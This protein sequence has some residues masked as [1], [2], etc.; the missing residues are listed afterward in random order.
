MQFFNSL[1][2]RSNIL[3]YKLSGRRPW[4]RGYEEYK[5][6]SIERVI[7]SSNFK[8]L[9][10]FKGYGQRVDERI[11]EYPWFFS[12]L[13]DQPEKLLDAGSILNYGYI[14]NNKKLSNKKIHI[15]TLSPEQNCYWQKGVSYVFDD[16]RSCPYK[17][18]YFDSIVCISTVEHIGLDNTMLYSNKSEHKE[19]SSDTFIFAIREFKRILKV[20]GKLYLTVPFGKHENHGWFQIFNSNMIDMIIQE[21]KPTEYYEECFKY[22][23][24]GWHKS[25][26]EESKEATY[27]D[28]HKNNNYDKDFAAASRAVICLELIK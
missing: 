3:F 5:I 25:T 24:F 18:S 7:N 15:L 13:S 17:D 26:R 8:N 14:L 21:F 12:R 16:I 1:K 28:I 10:S 9:L 22:D 23:F 27:F 6:Q 11:V 4:T 19:S 2:N 20:H